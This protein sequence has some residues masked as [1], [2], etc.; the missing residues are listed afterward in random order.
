MSL[1]DEKECPGSLA[2]KYG[3][4]QDF[5]NQYKG[6]SG[7]LYNILAR[8]FEKAMLITKRPYTVGG[9]V[10]SALTHCYM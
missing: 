2:T 3:I 7:A 5:M 6:Q 10:S 8:K 1:S 4:S 9:T